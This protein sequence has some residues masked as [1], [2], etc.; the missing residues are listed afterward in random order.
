MNVDWQVQDLHTSRGTRREVTATIPEVQLEYAPQLRRDWKAMRTRF[1]ESGMQ[2]LSVWGEFSQLAQCGRY[3]F[4]KRRD[5]S[6]FGWAEAYV[7]LTLAPEF[8][9]WTAAKLFRWNGR[10]IR[11]EPQ[12]ANTENVESMLLGEGFTLPRELQDYL[13]FRPK[14]P[15]LILRHRTTKEW[16]FCEVKRDEPVLPEQ[17]NALAFLHLLTGAPVAVVRLVP[18]GKSRKLRIHKARFT[19]RGPVQRSW[20]TG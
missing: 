17:V 11:K 12:K 20:L 10:P 9:S 7:A 1:L 13:D 18:E 3:L 6:S 14:N 15:D 2:D 16:R 5:R 4:T 19:Y 8:D